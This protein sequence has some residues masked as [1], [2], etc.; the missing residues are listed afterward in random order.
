M[1]R[2]WIAIDVHGGDYIPQNPIEGSLLA[3]HDLP[4]KDFGITLVGDER[5]IEQQLAGRLYGS[6]RLRILHSTQVVGMKDDPALVLRGKRGSSIHVGIAAARDGKV[7]AFVSAGNTG[8]VAYIARHLLRCIDN[9]VQPPIAATFP[10]LSGPKVVLDVGASINC[11]PVHL[12]QFGLMGAVYAQHV[13]GIE[14]PRIG[15]MSNGG[16]DTKGNWAI[17]GD[18]ETLGANG[19]F[20]LLNGNGIHF[21]GNVEGDNVF[22]GP[23]DVIVCDGFVG[24]VLLKV[25][26]G[27]F[28]AIKAA[29]GSVVRNGSLDQKIFAFI[30][31]ILLGPTIGAMK[32]LFAYEKY[33]GLP[34]LGLQGN[35]TIAHGKSTPVAI[36]NAIGNALRSAEHRI[37]THIQ[38]CLEKHA[39]ILKAPPPPPKG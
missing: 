6:D 1:P 28:H 22:D 26:E 12:A 32:H 4:N 18:R 36:M 14:H 16:E 34:L 5:V 27:E 33:G 24:N 3:L 11:K 37:D 17:V 9:V 21:H 35:V 31:R 15:L 39:D 8:A 23:A 29:V 38:E 20:R 10:T 19:I 25:A 7:D 30:G 2:F 13:L